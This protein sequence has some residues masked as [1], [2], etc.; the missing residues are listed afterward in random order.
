[1]DYLI[2]GETL[3]DIA[4]AIR[5][6][7]KKTAPIPAS[8]MDQE[9]MSIVSGG[10][11]VSDTTVTVS[12]VEK[13]KYFYDR[14]G[15]KREGSVEYGVIKFENVQIPQGSREITKTASSGFSTGTLRIGPISYGYQITNAFAANQRLSVDNARFPNFSLQINA[16]VINSYTV[17]IKATVDSEM[18]G[19]GGYII[20]TIY[21]PYMHR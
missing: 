8:D 12:N 13:G 15:V 19:S 5:S 16:S 18:T 3:T 17:Q 20:K 2:K 9:I 6:K 1:M 14:N 11:D 10:T 7:T 21:V 4:N